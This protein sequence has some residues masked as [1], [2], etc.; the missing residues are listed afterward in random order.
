MRGFLMMSVVALA[1]VPALAQSQAVS[2][3]AQLAAWDQCVGASAQDYVDMFGAVSMDADKMDKALEDCWDEEH[4]YLETVKQ[5]PEL[6]DG[7]MNEL[8]AARKAEIRGK[9][10]DVYV[11]NRKTMVPAHR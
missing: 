10:F 9:W 3:R 7:V 8:V 6:S 11:T 1:A 5:N 4:K 2:T